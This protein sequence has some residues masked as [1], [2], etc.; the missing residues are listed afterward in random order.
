MSV[1]N[2]KKQIVSALLIVMARQGYN[3]ASIQDIAK[4]AELTPG[5]LHYHFAS[6]RDI[7]LALIIEIEAIVEQRY[8]KRLKSAKSNW[9]ELYSLI[10]A[11][12]ALGDDANSN[13]VACWV[14]IA[15]EALKDEII[16]EAYTKTIE[17]KLSKLQAHVKSVAPHRS[18]KDIKAIT[19]LLMS[20]IQ[21]AYSL[22]IIAKATPKGFASQQIRK[23]AHALLNEV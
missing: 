9:D 12:V 11:Y 16:C 19:A 7:L 2:R 21:G 20:A 4:Q 13:A 15:A 6:K 14:G 17:R 23:T 1:K 3:G 18:P 10:D 8:E 22:S 5:L